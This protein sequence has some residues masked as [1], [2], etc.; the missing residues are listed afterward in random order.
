MS[1]QCWNNVVPTSPCVDVAT[2][3]FQHC[4]PGVQSLCTPA[5]R[6]VE[7]NS[8]TLKM[9]L[10]YPKYMYIVFCVISEPRYEKAGI[11]ETA[12]SAGVYEQSD[13]S[14]AVYGN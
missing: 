4:A 1:T 7:K 14:F 12:D 2:T 11:R 10:F 13:R 6:D 9:T 3:L 5:Q 8:F